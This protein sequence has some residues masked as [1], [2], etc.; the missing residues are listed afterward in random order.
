MTARADAAA[1]TGR[2]VVAAAKA[3]FMERDYEDVTL[4][5]VAADA[6]VTVQTVIRRF[7]SK[8]G[9]A[10]VVADEIGSDIRSS[11]EV[12]RPGDVA[13]AIHLLVASFEAMGGM[14]WRLLRQEH[15]I[16]LI[17][18]RLRLARAAH[19]AWIEACFAPLL[20]RRGAARERRILSLFVATDFYAWKLLRLDLG[21]PPAEVERVM[22]EMAK[23]ITGTS[24]GAAVDGEASVRRGGAARGRA[25]RSARGAKRLGRLAIKEGS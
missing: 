9:L 17:G 20:P 14:N 24:R 25:G 22:C 13:E 6:D 3:L 11:R 23:A 7:K 8:E 12:S 2:R 18:E 1:E 15:R 16:P 4:A 21:L 10:T 19:R 5:D